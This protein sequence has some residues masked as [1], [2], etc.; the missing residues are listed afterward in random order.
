MARAEQRK[1]EKGDSRFVIRAKKH[2]ANVCE[3]AFHWISPK[4]GLPAKADSP[5][6]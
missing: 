4:K 3:L 5:F 2:L 1:S 6:D